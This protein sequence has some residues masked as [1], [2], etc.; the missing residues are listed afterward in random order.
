MLSVCFCSS[1]VLLQR[2]PGADVA[3][4]ADGHPGLRWDA[5]LLRGG[6]DA[7]CLGRF[8]GILE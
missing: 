5:V 4:A 1:G 8:S 7:E 3:A 6:E 2:L